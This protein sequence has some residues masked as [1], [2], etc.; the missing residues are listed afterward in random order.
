MPTLDVLKF[1]ELWTSPTLFGLLGHLSSRVHQV[2]SQV[3]HAIFDADEAVASVGV[4]CGDTAT[5]GL[6][7]CEV[8][9]VFVPQ[10]QVL[11]K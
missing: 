11:K 7:D 5:A 10:S 8:F 2:D 1:F 4:G 9:T 3:D 6:E